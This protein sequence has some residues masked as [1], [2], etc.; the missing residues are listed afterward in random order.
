MQ[1]DANLR[2]FAVKSTQEGTK[3][4]AAA[5]V[6][7]WMLIMMIKREKKMVSP[8]CGWNK[9]VI[10]VSVLSRHQ[11]T[12]FDVIFGRVVRQAGD[13]FWMRFLIECLCF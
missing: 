7:T 9:K 5:S 8:S 6:F 13:E 3:R 12:P 4:V 10:T 2:G 1:N 11:Q